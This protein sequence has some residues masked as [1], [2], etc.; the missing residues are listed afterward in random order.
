MYENKEKEDGKLKKKKK[1][2]YTFDVSP[3]CFKYLC[4]AKKGKIK[5]PF[6]NLAGQ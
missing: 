5:T 1:Y 3:R 2:I 4:S 6:P